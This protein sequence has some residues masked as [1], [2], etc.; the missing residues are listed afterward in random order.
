M[1]TAVIGSAQSTPAAGGNP[2]A[3][4]TSGAQAS[5]DAQGNST[6]P[7]TATSTGT[8]SLGQVTVPAP[9]DPTKKIVVLP[10]GS[11]LH[12]RLTTTLTSKTS[13]AGDK[14]TGV[15]T[16]QVVSGDQTL[17]PEGSLVDG[18]VT[19]VKPS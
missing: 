9:F 5:S 3:Q 12:V 19:M 16:Q 15:V 18:H 10:G 7:G 13:A 4:A 1:L 14:F 6:A 17:V 2:G 8:M 11:V